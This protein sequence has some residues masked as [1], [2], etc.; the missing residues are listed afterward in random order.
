VNELVTTVRRSSRVVTA[1]QAAAALRAAANSGGVSVGEL[2][3]LERD[4]TAA[5]PGCRRVPP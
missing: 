5:A 1:L 4:F 2:T 3:A